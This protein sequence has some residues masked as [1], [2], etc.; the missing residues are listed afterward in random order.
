MKTIMSEAVEG[1]GGVWIDLCEPDE[2]ECQEIE[3]L[4]GIR[5]PTLE[6]LQ[7]IESSSRLRIHDGVLNM[8]APLMT[9]SEG[10]RW[11]MAPAGFILT[12]DVLVTTHFAHI[13]AFDIAAEALK[14]R[15]EPTPAG[16]LV[17]V[18]EELVDRAADQL[19]H[20]SEMIA[21]VSRTIFYTDLDARGLSR[22]TAIL[23]HSIIKLGRAYDRASRVRYMFLSIGR[24][25]SFV[26]DRC[27][28]HLDDDLAT[29]LQSL[30][31]DIASLDEFEMSLSSRTQ[32]LQDAANS[33]ISIEQ[34]DVVKVLTVASVA[35]IPPVLVVGIYG[36]NFH[37][38]PEL[39]WA[40]GYPMALGLCLVTTLIPYLWFKWRKWL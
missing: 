8:S 13:K 15:P 23:R 32:F 14:S 27:Q 18:L 1:I 40:W 6:A 2:A 20:V 35:G 26:A 24:M 11:V 12:G 10:E 37:N 34:N 31:H 9:P 25:A 19:E 29:R 16:V 3:K 7:E 28:D 30:I 17:R 21:S 4:Y 22:E 39:S 36:M 5:V 33:L 38:M